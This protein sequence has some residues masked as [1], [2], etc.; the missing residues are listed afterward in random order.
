MSLKKGEAKSA[1]PEVCPRRRNRRKKESQDWKDFVE[2]T[3]TQREDQRVGKGFWSQD[4]G[5]FCKATKDA[6]VSTAASAVRDWDDDRECLFPARKNSK[7]IPRKEEN[8]LQT[9]A[10][11]FGMECAGSTKLSKCTEEALR[12]LSSLNI[13]SFLLRGPQKKRKRF[14]VA[15][16]P[17]IHSS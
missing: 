12:C 11:T 7:D 16:I 8:R 9:V 15:Q 13:K 6:V 1:S 10:L 3:V 4:H 14:S 17:R 2:L 5:C